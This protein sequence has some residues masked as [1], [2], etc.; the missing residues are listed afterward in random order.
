MSMSPIEA[1][2]KA[3]Y[4]G[5][6]DQPWDASTV[7]EEAKF[8]LIATSAVNAALAAAAESPAVLEYAANAISQSS[9]MRFDG[10]WLRID[11]L[12]PED[13]DYALS[14]A[15]SALA[16]AHGAIRLMEVVWRAAQ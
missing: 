10:F 2:A 9:G 12:E 6:E 1:A 8:R 3:I 5:M 11:E 15:Q 4:Q 16:A 7:E 13:R 14:E